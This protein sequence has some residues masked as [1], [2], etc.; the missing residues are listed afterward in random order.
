MG[1]DAVEFLE[2]IAGGAV[3]CILAFRKLNLPET[4]DSRFCLTGHKFSPHVFHYRG[5][6]QDL[7]I[8]PEINK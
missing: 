1:D 2:V 7:L 3:H 6:S 4:V 8:R 5:N